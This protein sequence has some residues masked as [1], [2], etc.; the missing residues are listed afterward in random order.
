MTQGAT[1]VRDPEGTRLRVLDAAER[2]FA[3]RGFAGTSMRDISVASGT[4][5]PL[6]HH[7]FGSKEE[8]YSAVKQRLIED[9]NRRLPKAA[10]VK[11][12]P[13]RVRAEMRRLFVFLRDSRAL[14]RISA[15]ARLEGDDRP[16]PGERELLEALRQ[17]IETA[18]RRR[19]IRRDLDPT[20]LNIMLVGLVSYW[21]DNRLYY[22]DDVDGV[23]DDN[24]YLRQAIALV[25]RGLAP[26]S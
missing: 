3:E 19:L 9:Y 1:R 2:V 15:W 4:S 24:A 23:P 7:H 6:I 5:Q 18:Q 14:L 20:L 12:R 26:R 21:L 25:E 17:R 11:D 8:L 16:W 13:L 10:R 22:A